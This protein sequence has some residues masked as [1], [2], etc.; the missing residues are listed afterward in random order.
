MTEQGSNKGGYVLAFLAGA[1]GG[2][3][4]ARKAP[5]LIAGV[6]EH[7]QQMCHQMMEGGCCAPEMQTRSGAACC[8]TV[9]QGN[10]EQHEPR[11]A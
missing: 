2:A 9:S 8:E 3:M 7:C 11:A 5:A 1:I 6:Q 4:I 10:E